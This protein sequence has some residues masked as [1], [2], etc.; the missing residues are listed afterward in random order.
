MSTDHS[1][2]P[3]NTL[4]HEAFLHYAF[5]RWLIP[6]VYV[7]PDPTK[8]GEKKPRV[9]WKDL[10]VRPDLDELNEWQRQ[11]PDSMWAMLTGCRSGVITLD[12][13]GSAGAA[14][15]ALLG[16][17]PHRITPNGF[18]LDVALPDFAVRTIA[19]GN[20]PALAEAF[21]GMD[22]RG[23]GG[24]I[25]V[26]G[27]TPFGTY[28]RVRPLDP[29]TLDLIP[30]ELIPFLHRKARKRSKPTSLLESSMS[31]TPDTTDTAV[32]EGTGSRLHQSALDRLNGG[33]TRN[34]TGFALACQLRDAGLARDDAEAVMVAYQASVPA[35]DA[36]GGDA[37]YTV[38]EAM[39]SLESAYSSPPRDPTSA[40]VPDGIVVNDPDVQEADLVNAALHRLAASNE[41]APRLFEQQ[42]S[43]V[44]V[45]TDERG[46]DRIEVLNADA[47]RNELANRIDWFQ[48][49]HDG[50]NIV[51]RAATVPSHLIRQVLAA[52]R[53]DR[54]P[55]LAGII[56]APTILTDGT[57]VTEPGYH[58][59]S[60]LWLAMGNLPPVTVPDQ[61]TEADLA[62]A[63]ALI[64]DTILGEFAYSGEASQA[65]AVALL[66]TAVAPD[67]FTGRPPIFLVSANQAGTGKT[68]L[69]EVVHTTAAGYASVATPPE[70]DEEFRKFITA[71]LLQGRTLLALDNLAGTLSSPVLAQAA[72]APYWS[73]RVLGISK[74]AE[75]ENRLCISITGNNIAL[76]GDLARRCVLIELE[77]RQHRPWT[78]TF[79]NPDRV[80]WVNDHRELAIG[81]ALTVLRA[82][83]AAGCPAP[84]DRPILGS[85][86]GWADTM[87][88]VLHHAGIY[89]FLTNTD[90]I[91]QQADQDS[92]AW[93]ALLHALDDWFA[94]RDGHFTIANFEQEAQAMLQ[95]LGADA[96]TLPSKVAYALD[97]PQDQAR[98]VRLGK[99]LAAVANRRFDA[100]G[101]RIEKDLDTATRSNRYHVTK[102]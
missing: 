4:P 96:P 7:Q 38:E 13:D 11:W 47:S 31:M 95:R 99:V 37:P 72:T 49:K 1:P 65:Q 84:P 76:G 81:A 52:D 77:A 14:T 71:S 60:S 92:L 43:L 57:L 74:T 2:A 58:P 63:V 40:A 17:D 12:F 50:E 45:R 69:V 39:A 54:F 35:T 23:E 83:H 6:M 91:H 73:D 75:V 20:D 85:F 86:Q 67:S 94:D 53:S 93:A 36:T 18:H 90:A 8:K 61:P 97:H 64:T 42:G 28:Q 46:R 59:R 48:A 51:Y 88:G 9:K 22:I 102:D 56:T 62:D 89:G 21:P 55:R 5:G 70:R 87:G 68:Y 79:Q 82:W 80:G 66:L 98:R 30:D 19:N 24:L 29:D 100:T 33:G 27:S 44:R 3:T 41:E 10:K 16:L 26:C 32:I 78:R 34:D 15:L 25:V 101:I